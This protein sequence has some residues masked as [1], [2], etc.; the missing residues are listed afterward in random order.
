MPAI[1]KLSHRHDAIIDWLITNPDKSQGDCAAFFG[2][3]QPWLSQI[4]HSDAFQ[5]VYRQRCEEKGMIATHTI[6]AKMA[7]I[8]ALALDSIEKR[9]VNGQAT[10]RLLTDSTKMALQ[11]LGYLD[12][13]EVPGSIQYH[14]HQHVHLENKEALQAAR[15][16][17][18][19]GKNG[20]S[21]P[22]NEIPAAREAAL[23]AA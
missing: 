7:G 11:G 19:A 20:Q 8:A 21:A 5:M 10:E 23:N 9:I 14:S 1:Q 17:A 12:G 16:R 3:S 13:G 18:L 2:Y 4:I 15:E 22:K 6:V